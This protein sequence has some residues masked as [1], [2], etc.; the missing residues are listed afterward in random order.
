MERTV[1]RVADEAAKVE[2]LIGVVHGDLH[3]GQVLVSDGGIVGLLDVD[4]A[5][6]VLLAHDAKNL[7][8]AS[9]ALAPIRPEGVHAGGHAVAR[10]G[11]G[12]L[13]AEPVFE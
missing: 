6:D 3:A 5:G 13:D 4:G 9:I 10:A 11:R 1:R 8:H 2:G 7:G 12:G